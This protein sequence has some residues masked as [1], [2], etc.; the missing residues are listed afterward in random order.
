MATTRQ[1]PWRY[2]IGCWRPKNSTNSIAALYSEYSECW[3]RKPP[4]SAASLGFVNLRLSWSRCRLPPR[5]HLH[6][7]MAAVLARLI[8]VVGF[9]G[10]QWAVF[11]LSGTATKC[12]KGAA[13]I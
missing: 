10:T 2:W 4:E 9:D 6:A 1:R 12:R 13:L 7:L 3:A 5:Q 8:S 11:T